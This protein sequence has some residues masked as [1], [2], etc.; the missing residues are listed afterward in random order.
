MA[1]TRIVRQY[2][3]AELESYHSFQTD[4][5]ADFQVITGKVIFN[6]HMPVEMGI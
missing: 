6:Y 4:F 5:P 1:F 2:F 3:T